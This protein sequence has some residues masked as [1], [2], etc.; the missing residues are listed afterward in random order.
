MTRGATTAGQK[1]W[2]MPA[3]RKLGCSPAVKVALGQRRHLGAQLH[4][5]HGRW[6]REAGMAELLRDVAEQGFDGRRADLREHRGAV[7]V[8]VGDEG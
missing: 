8:G 1:W 6:Q 2:Y 5:R 7:V 4:L 3:P